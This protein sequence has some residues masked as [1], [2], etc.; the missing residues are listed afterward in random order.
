V[1]P[2]DDPDVALIARNISKRFGKKTV[3]E[4]VDLDLRPGEAVALVGENGAGK[5][6]LLRICAGFLRAD[7]GTVRVA[8]RIGYCPQDPGILDLLTGEEH[9]LLLGRAA[10]LSRQAALLEGMRNLELF[11]FPA[12]QRTVAKDLSGGTRQKLNLAMA[13][14][15][16]P[17]V[18]LLD[19]PYQGFDRGTYINFWDHVD[20]W[21][22]AGKAVLVV[23]HMLAELSR[24]DHVVELPVHETVSRNHAGIG[25]HA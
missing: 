13:L 8:G 11:G 24:V 3:L 16:D 17:R 9:M 22:A 4:N 6:T 15:G 25:G 1:V 2:R 18:L 10:G 7:S 5:S 14:L 21:R 12:R 19:E 23:T 20:A